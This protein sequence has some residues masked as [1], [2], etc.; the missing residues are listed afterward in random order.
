MAFFAQEKLQALMPRE[1][2]MRLRILKIMAAGTLLPAALALAHPAP[3]Q[4]FEE[5]DLLSDASVDEEAGIIFAR[6]QAARGEWLEA[7]GTLER[8]LAVHPKSNE[9]KRLQGMYLCTVDD[10]LGGAVILAQ[11]KK[12]KFAKG[13]LEEARATCKEPDPVVDAGEGAGNES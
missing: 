2:E 9:A 4:S 1:A 11:L 3:A 6:S 5:L 12:K 7:I 13:V 8:V 10:R